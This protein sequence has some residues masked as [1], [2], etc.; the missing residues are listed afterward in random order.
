MSTL[1]VDGVFC[2]SLVERKDRRQMLLEE[3]APLGLDIEF[4][5]AERDSE[6]PERGCYESHQACA[7]MAIERGYERVL[8]LEDD[9]TLLNFKHEVIRRANTFLKFKKP[10]I[11]YLGGMLGRMWLIPFPNIVRARLTG[12]HAYVLSRQGCKKLVR[13]KFVGTPIDTHY[14]NV[15][16]SYSVYPMLSAQQPEDEMK[17]DIVENRVKRKGGAS[18]KDKRYWNNNFSKQP[19]ALKRDIW[20]T[21]CMRWL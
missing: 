19:S 10:E 13:Q 20:R 4:Y 14:C 17:S 15:V 2:I 9:A 18:V 11:L 8:I 5:L 1:E 3:F 16:K 7:A 21:L 12:T 6:D